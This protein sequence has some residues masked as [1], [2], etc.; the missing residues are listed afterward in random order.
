MRGTPAATV[1]RRAEVR[2]VA[3]AGI[4]NV[5][6][7][8]RRRLDDE[9]RPQCLVAVEQ[10]ARRPVPHR[11]ERD[12]NAR[13]KLD[14]IAPIVG[15][16]ADRRI[17]VAHDRVVTE[18]RDNAA[19]MRGRESRQRRDIEMVIMAMRHQHRVDRRQ[20]VECDARIV[21][22][23][24]PDESKRRG[25][26]RPQRVGQNVHA[27]RLQQNRRVPDE[28]DTPL[29]TR[30]PCRRLVGIR[31][32]CPCRPFGLAAAGVPA[33][34][35]GSAVGRRAVRIEK[36]RAVEVIRYRA[37]VVARRRGANAESAK[38]RGRDGGESSEHAAA[39]DFHMRR[40]SPGF[41]G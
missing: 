24:R 27:R 35:V 17:V 3:V 18:R 13:S 12:R 1:A 37:V 30:N 7:A 10:M 19:S 11:R 14:A 5:I 28:R 41:P 29:G 32:R 9:G 20:R 25:A 2:A 8:A 40:V 6:D 33:Q 15:L 16:D 38:S 23:F 34:Q 26:L 4:G 39:G 22:P 31:A 36:P 21:H